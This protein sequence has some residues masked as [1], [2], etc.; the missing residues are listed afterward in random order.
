MEASNDGQWTP[1]R[2]RPYDIASGHVPRYLNDRTAWL[3]GLLQGNN[4]VVLRRS[5]HWLVKQYVAYS[6][7]FGFSLSLYQGVPARESSLLL[8]FNCL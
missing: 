4:A 3:E 2:Q 5:S 6:E 1:L 8:C 7:G